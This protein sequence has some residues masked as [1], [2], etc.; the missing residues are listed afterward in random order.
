MRQDE[1]K[2]SF[3][4]KHHAEGGWYKEIWQSE[5]QTEGKKI[6]SLM[7]YL[8]TEE[9]ENRWHRL[10][11]DE[12][13]LF[14]E[15]NPITVTMGGQGK[16]PETETKLTLGKDIFHCVIPAGTW[17]KSEVPQGYALV[18]CVVTPAYAEEDW[19]IR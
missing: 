7:Y 5:K 16:N 13:W 9:E 6:C 2:T 8:L 10:K 14:H 15:G 17:Q 3:A 11:S 12:I 1:I 4:M 19:E 18:S